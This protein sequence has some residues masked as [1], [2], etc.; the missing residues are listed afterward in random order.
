MGIIWFQGICSLN[1]CLST[2]RGN[3]ITEFFFSFCPPKMFFL[4]TAK[5]AV[6]A[7]I[8]IDHN[9]WR[10]RFIEN[11]K[12]KKKEKVRWAE[13]LCILFVTLSEIY[14]LE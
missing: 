3:F 2:V 9:I 14:T 4:L 6:S 11:K 1:L 10:N 8:V 7:I 12:K 5:I 13:K